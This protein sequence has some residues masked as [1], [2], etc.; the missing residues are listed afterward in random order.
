MVFSLRNF[1]GG[2]I[3]IS[4]YLSYLYTMNISPSCIARTLFTV[5]VFQTD[6]LKHQTCLSVMF[7]CSHVK[8]MSFNEVTCEISYD[9][10]ASD[11]SRK[12]ISKAS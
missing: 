1:R 10:E 2:V 7:S 6:P 9:V 4:P 12:I 8:R 3:R 5:V 11:G